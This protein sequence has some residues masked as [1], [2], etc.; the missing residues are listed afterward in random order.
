MFTPNLTF[1][2]TRASRRVFLSRAA[3]GVGKIALASLLSPA[4]FSAAVA[5]QTKTRNKDKWSGV[6]NPFHYPPKAKRVIWL[7]MAGGPSHLENFE[8]KRKLAEVVWQ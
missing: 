8:S 3:Q 6:V 5:A 1:T 2:E 7:T 4:L